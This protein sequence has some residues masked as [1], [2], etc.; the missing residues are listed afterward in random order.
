MRRKK[1]TGSK[2]YIGR[3]L[4]G[5]RGPQDRIRER[6][7]DE[8]EIVGKVFALQNGVEVGVRGRGGSIYS[9]V[10]R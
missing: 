9:G 6:E 8:T 1:E 2:S 5:A 10:A 4:R 7:K 3:E